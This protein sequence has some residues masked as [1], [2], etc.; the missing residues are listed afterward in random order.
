MKAFDADPA[1]DSP[2]SDPLLDALRRLHPTPCEINTAELF[3]RSGYAAA[4]ARRRSSAVPSWPLAASLLLVA[5][6]AGLAGYSLGDPAP[7]APLAI[8]RVVTPSPSGASPPTDATGA[9]PAPAEPAPTE[10]APTEPPADADRPVAA[11]QT[12]PRPKDIAP[13]QTRSLALNQM[14]PAWSRWFVWQPRDMNAAAAASDRLTI[15]PTDDQWQQLVHLR[16]PAYGFDNAQSS[17]NDGQPDPQP[18][19]SSMATEAA[20]QSLIH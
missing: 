11:P 16:M 1:P 2:A 3:Y 14:L 10:P 6:V 8:E 7:T 4:V 20:L 13:L 17:A 18:M 5:S 15:R 9:L 12:H 19:L